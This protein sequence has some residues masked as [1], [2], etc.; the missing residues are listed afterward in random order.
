MSLLT[1]LGVALFSSLGMW[2]LERAEVKREIGRRFTAQ[3]EQPY[4][5]IQLGEQKNENLQYQKIRLRGR[6]DNDHL[7]LV[8]NQLNKGVAGYHVLQ[9]FFAAGESTALLVNRGWVAADP[10]RSRFPDILPPRLANEVFG[11]LT[12]PSMEGFRLG[13]VNMTGHWPQRIPFV[14]LERI[15][16]GLD[17]SI[18][19]YLLWQ[20]A[21][22]DDYYVRDWQPVW[23]PPEKSEAYAVQW[24]SFGVITL[25]LYLV[26]NLKPLVK[27][28]DDE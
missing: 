3:L 5:Y 20:A 25:L 13:E 7:I 23:S 22:I 16:Q 24:F 17:F 2:Q 18:Y 15:G 27:E 4:R 11:T 26:L 10:D 9:P 19:P 1:F 8:D 21:E 12:I 28:I 6:F 14:D